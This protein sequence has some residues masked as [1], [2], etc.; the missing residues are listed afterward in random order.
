MLKMSSISLRVVSE[1]LSKTRNSF[2]GWTHG[3]LSHIFS[4]ANIS[5]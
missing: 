1:S 2:V 3:E 4:S 5:S